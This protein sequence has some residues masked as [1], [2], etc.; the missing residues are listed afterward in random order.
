MHAS[1]KPLHFYRTQ[2]KSNLLISVV[3]KKPII[4]ACLCRTNYRYL[5]S[6]HPKYVTSKSMVNGLSH[7][8]QRYSGHL[9][10]DVH[11]DE[12][13][14]HVA[15]LKSNESKHLEKIPPVPL[16]PRNWLPQEGDEANSQSSR[17]LYPSPRSSRAHKIL[18]IT[19]S[20][21]HLSKDLAIS[22]LPSI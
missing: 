19:L 21:N 7:N 22:L 17:C 11:P 20:R 12:M 10:T 8:K 1:E 2:H 3:Q 13:R 5:V 4:Q 15:M 9:G 14:S 18:V 6:A 16:K